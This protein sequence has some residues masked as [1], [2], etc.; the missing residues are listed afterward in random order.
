MAISSA[1]QG[2]RLAKFRGEERLIP[3]KVKHSRL[4]TRK[5][6]IA[7]ALKMYLVGRKIA[8]I[9]RFF[10]VVP[11]TISES[12][13]EFIK[14]LPNPEDIRAYRE[15]KSQILDGVELELIRKMSDKATI[16]AASLNNA[17]Y[18][19]Q[20]VYN[21]NRLECGKSTVHAEV[22]LSAAHEIVINSVI[23]A[24][25]SAEV[26]NIKAEEAPE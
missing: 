22:H 21:S 1:S 17:A 2:R 8:E 25:V 20:Q 6:D 12:L 16:K 13:S 24:L 5:V 15:S 19:Y 26:S 9:A 18:A 7:E 4:S 14:I 23:D 11:S 3:Q 10:G